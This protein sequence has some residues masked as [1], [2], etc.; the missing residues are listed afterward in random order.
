VGVKKSLVSALFCFVIISVGARAGSAQEV[1]PLEPEWLRQRYAEGWQKVQE[2]VLRRVTEEGTL[3][4]FGYGAEGM[5]WVAQK[6][7]QQAAGLKRRYDASPS[8]DLAELI[9]QLEDQVLRLEGIIDSAPSAES[10]A[11]EAIEACTPLYDVVVSADPQT[12]AQGVTASA[13]AWFHNNCGI[14]G[15]T[16]TTAQAQA[17]SVTGE[18]SV[19]HNDPKNGGAWLDSYSTASANGSTGCRSY[20]AGTVMYPALP[21][22][23]MEEDENFSCNPINSTSAAAVRGPV[24]AAP[25]ATLLLPYFQVDL[26]N[27][28]GVNTLFSIN[29][30][31]ASAQLAHVTVWS[32]WSIPVMDFYVYL[33]GFDVQTLSVRDIL[34]NGLLSQTGSGVS[35]RGSYSSPNSSFPNCNSSASPPSA[36]VYPTPAITTTFRTHLKALLTGKQSPVDNTCAG[37]NYGD[38]IARGYITV[39][40]ANSCSLLFPSSNGYFISGG[41]GVAGNDNVLWGDYF[42]VNPGENFAQG[43]TLVHIEADATAFSTPGE[44]TFYGRYVG[45]SAADNRKPLPTSFATRYTNGGAFTGGT[46]LIVWRDSKASPGGNCAAGSNFGSL[47]ESQVVAFD[48][49]ENV[50]LDCRSCGLFPDETQYID[51][52]SLPL[53]S[54]FGWLYLNLN[55]A[56]PLDPSLGSGYAGIAQA[57]VVTITSSEGRFSVGYDAVQLDNA[58]TARSPGGR[59]IP[60]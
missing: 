8:E 25:A 24:A 33:T 12:G 22:A 32:T 37:T 18:T 19:T 49:A 2:G 58:N 56:S 27:S 28:T 45:G 52:S 36:P 21:S 43:E 20:A 42:Y 46:E 55:H 13:S 6:Y 5:Q 51:S 57:W 7:K 54:D 30:S 53:G 41:L 38:N 3:E 48:E 15:D 60:P 39:D 47:D 23:Y 14:L 40:D 1:Q 34:A 11:E 10:F 31:V 26:D 29:N 17:V 50:D 16:F 4:T 9:D 35:P 59:I 44:Y